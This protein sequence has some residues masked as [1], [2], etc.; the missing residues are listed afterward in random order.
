MIGFYSN[1][2]FGFK[3]SAIAERK[4]SNSRYSHGNCDTLKRGAP[5]ESV[6][7][8]LRY[9]LGNIGWF[10]TITKNVCFCFD[11][12]ITT[13]SRVVHWVALCYYN[14]RKREATYEGG[15]SNL[16]YRVRYNYTFEYDATRKSAISNLCY[17]LRNHNTLKRATIVKCIVANVCCSLGNDGYA[18]LNLKFCRN[19][20]CYFFAFAFFSGASS[21]IVS[22]NSSGRR[23]L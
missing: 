14:T 3:Q 20:T 17:R 6:S 22:C 13:L 2:R 7:S 16:R 11:N 23:F 15:P 10:A 18:I 8:N 21:T 4:V 1:D 12:S 19:I 5:A 9:W